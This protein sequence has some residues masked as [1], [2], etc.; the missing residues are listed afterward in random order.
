MTLDESDA[1]R[2]DADDPGR[3][4][5][6]LVPPAAGG[7]YEESAYLVGNSLGLQPRAV[8]DEMLAHLDDW[9]TLGVEG[10]VEAHDPWENLPQRLALP[11]ARIVGARPEE[12]VVM[13]T[14][15]VNLHLLMVS[16][17]RPSGARHK[18]VIEDAAFPSD[19]YAVRSQAVLHGLDPET[20]V[21]RLRPRDGE[22]VLRTEDVIAAITDEVA[23]VLL[24][25]VHY[26]TG[27]R[28]D[29]PAITAAGHAAGAVVGWDL[30]HAAGNVELRLHDWDVDFAAWCNY[31]FLNSGPGSPGSAFVHTRH[32]GDPSIMRLDGWWGTEAATRFDMAP[33]SRPPATADAWQISTPQTLALAPMTSA[34]QL[35][36]EAG[37]PELRARSRRLTDYLIEA[38]DAI[39]PGR[40]L[41]IITPREPERRGAQISVR[42][43][44]QDVGQ[45][46]KRL[47]FEHG[48]LV[49]SRKPDVIRLTPVPLYSSYHDC[50]RAS[51]ALAALC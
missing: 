20:A 22:D 48:V 39:S 41:E 13:N 11:S 34:L 35:F 1:V 29:I 40:P 45:L 16:F 32:L 9:A 17:Y 47:R 43:H 25:G 6:F 28:C 33:V 30:A 46:A 12:T 19:S 44:G 4:S 36:D 42:V 37:L 23:L 26:L 3:R 49:D 5:M 51:A 21:V 7:R 24:A 27:A 18:I 8:R 15:T 31:K 50:W 10:H 14:L 38:L 2:R